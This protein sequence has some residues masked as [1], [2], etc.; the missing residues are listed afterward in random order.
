MQINSIGLNF[1]GNTVNSR[2]LVYVKPVVSDTMAGYNRHEQNIVRTIGFEQYQAVCNLPD[3]E[4]TK[5]ISYLLKN[6][7]NESMI[8]IGNP[9]T[10][11]SEQALDNLISKYPELVNKIERV[12]IVPSDYENAVFITKSDKEDNIGVEYF[13]VHSDGKIRIKTPFWSQAQARGLKATRYLRPG[14][15]FTIE[16]DN[17]HI[18][19]EKNAPD[20]KP[21]G[22]S[23]IELVELL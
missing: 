21:S 4:E 1:T 15:V 6:L 22:I 19:L 2:K 3:V 20:K 13:M 9:Y 17:H 5:K 16:G 14:D 8:I 10:A 12:H 7:D 11:E 18:K 23:S